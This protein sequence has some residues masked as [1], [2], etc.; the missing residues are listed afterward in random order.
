MYNLHSQLYLLTAL[1]EYLS[2]LLEYLDLFGRCCKLGDRAQQAFGRAWAL[3][4]MLLATPLFK[5]NV[6]HVSD[7]SAILFTYYRI[8]RKF[9]GRKVWRKCKK[10]QFGE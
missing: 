6:S 3:S 7:V 5:T 8:G 10:Y 2:V 9:G 1:I 4:S